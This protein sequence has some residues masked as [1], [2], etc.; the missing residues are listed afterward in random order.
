MQA[1]QLGG[2]V[3][4][5]ARNSRRCDEF[6]EARLGPS[7]RQGEGRP[8]HGWALLGGSRLASLMIR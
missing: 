1:M 6:R 8:L 7:V 4:L 2:R 3:L 5:G